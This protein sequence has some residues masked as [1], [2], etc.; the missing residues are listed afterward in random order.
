MP[1]K[2]RPFPERVVSI[3]ERVGRPMTDREIFGNIKGSGEYSRD[4]R[5]SLDSMVASGTIIKE[6]KTEPMTFGSK[7]TREFTYYSMASPSSP[8]RKPT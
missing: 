5:K 3:I 1:S 7:V 8:P 2:R 4:L 6:V